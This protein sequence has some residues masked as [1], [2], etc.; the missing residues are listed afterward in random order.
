[1]CIGESWGMANDREW[2]TVQYLVEGFK[3]I[4]YFHP[5]MLAPSKARV[6][7]NNIQ[8]LHHSHF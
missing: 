1:M 8:L 4:D 2:R 5:S 7:P 3:V 6:N